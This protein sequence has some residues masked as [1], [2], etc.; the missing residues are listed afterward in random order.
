MTL[1]I[2]FAA[3]YNITVPSQCSLSQCSSKVEGDSSPFWEEL[4]SELLLSSASSELAFFILRR[5]LANHVE[6]CKQI[7][8]LNIAWEWDYQIVKR[9]P[10]MGY[11]FQSGSEPCTNLAS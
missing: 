4:S 8:T 5:A 9:V 7:V 11:R 6:T 3:R 2:T 10:L 1:L